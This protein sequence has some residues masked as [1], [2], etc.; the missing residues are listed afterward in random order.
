MSDNEEADFLRLLQ[1]SF[2]GITTVKSLELAVKVSEIGS[3][4]LTAYS[5]TYA[6]SQF[7]Q[8][9]IKIMK[10]AIADVAHLDGFLSVFIRDLNRKLGARANY[11]AECAAKNLAITWVS[12]FVGLLN[13]PVQMYQ[14]DK[15][16]FLID[17]QLI[18]LDEGLVHV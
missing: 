7:L 5:K 1:R 13:L 10:V 2:K 16:T 4:V 15:D 18:Q 8:S 14:L 12:G 6:T 11:V 9:D 3:V 17:F